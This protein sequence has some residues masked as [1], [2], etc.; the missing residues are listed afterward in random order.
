MPAWPDKRGI[1]RPVARHERLVIEKDPLARFGRDI[2]VNMTK[3]MASP[4]LLAPLSKS[5]G[6][7]GRCGQV[8]ETR[9][10]PDYV[11]MLKA[12]EGGKEAMDEIPR[13]STSQWKPNWQYV[14]EMKRFGVLP[15]SFDLAAQKLDAFETDQRYWTSLWWSGK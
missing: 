9:E 5:A 8:F 15:E 10:D 6:G 1:T 7:W 2:L 11:L 12:I 13:Y 3:P 4:L 14:R